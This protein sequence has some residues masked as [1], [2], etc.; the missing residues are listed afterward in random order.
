MNAPVETPLNH[1]WNVGDIALLRNCETGKFRKV[2][3]KEVV[4]GG[5]MYYV[6][7]TSGIVRLAYQYSLYLC[8]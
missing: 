3:I 6:K 8:A 7:Y 4:N 1:V 2:T 5:D